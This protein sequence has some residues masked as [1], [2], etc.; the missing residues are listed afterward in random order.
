MSVDYVLAMQKLARRFP[1]VFLCPSALDHVLDA[2]T[3]FNH[4][5]PTPAVFLV[6]F[7]VDI[8]QLLDEFKAFFCPSALDHVLDAETVFT[9]V[10]SSARPSVSVD[11]VFAMQKLAR[12]F[13]AVFLVLFLVGMQTAS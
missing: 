11:Y 9:R 7:L 1:A 4:P 5:R 13:P 10:A 6:L 3:V 12:R 2:E 8:D